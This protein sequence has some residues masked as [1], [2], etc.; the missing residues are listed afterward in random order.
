MKGNEATILLYGDGWADLCWDGDIRDSIPAAEVRV[1]DAAA[2]VRIRG[3]RL[4]RD[5]AWRDVETP[6]GSA[7]EAIL[8]VTGTAWDRTIGVQS[9]TIDPDDLFAL[10]LRAELAEAR[11]RGDEVSAIAFAMDAANDW[12][13][14]VTS[15][16]AL[17]DLTTERIGIVTNANADW[18]STR[19][20]I[21]AA[22]DDW[23]NDPEAWE[24]RN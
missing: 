10:D 21:A 18:G 24:A 14:G 9:E 8:D 19:G 1:S 22:L 20:G 11:A 6:A 5:T 13:R 16:E 7:R 4:G 2:E 23:A 3:V 17:V 12:G 15:G